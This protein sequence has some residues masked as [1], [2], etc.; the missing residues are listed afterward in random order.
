MGHRKIRRRRGCSQVLLNCIFA[1]KVE[2]EKGRKKNKKRNRR[3]GIESLRRRRRKRK[4]EEEEEW[5]TGK[6]DHL[7]IDLFVSKHYE[8][9]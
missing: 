8:T 3:G 9:F 1:E 5:E 4:K 2:E 6:I 7:Y